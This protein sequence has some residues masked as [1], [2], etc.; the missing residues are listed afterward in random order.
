MGRNQIVRYRRASF[1]PFSSSSETAAVE[2]IS[3]RAAPPYSCWVVLEEAQPQY[4]HFAERT[5]EHTVC[6]LFSKP[7]KI[8]S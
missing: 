3:C 7:E 2:W 4:L 6:D 5:T 1:S 8:R